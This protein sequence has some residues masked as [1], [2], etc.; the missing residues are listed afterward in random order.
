MEDA[1]EATWWRRR[2]E[3]PYQSWQKGEGLPVYK[4]A[5]VPD[6][7]TLEVAAWPRIGQ[8]AAFV[9]LAEQEHDDAWVIEIAP[10]GQTEV[11][12]HLFEATIFALDGRGATTIWQADGP[13]RTVEWQS[14]SIF[15]PPLNCYYQHFNL[16]GQRP[17]RLVA[18]TNAPMVMNIY[19]DAGFFFEDRSV[20]SARYNAEEYYFTG[21]GE[22]TA[23]NAWK[24][25]FIPDI[26]SFTLDQN[27]NR[28]AGFGREQPEQIEYEDEDPSI[29]ETY[30]AE[31][32]RSG[33]EIVL[34]RPRYREA[35]RT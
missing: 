32:A 29:Y 13:K 16:D 15:S 18:V 25:N 3:S 7:Y 22:K 14:G 34:P 8:K 35:V 9:N 19:R 24:T 21:P 23:R 5:Y 6:L 28:G 33:A 11:I 31:C 12:H 10:G 4:G 1:N 27:L 26:R 30:A 20:F 2:S 17:A